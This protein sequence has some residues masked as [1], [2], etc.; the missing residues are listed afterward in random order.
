MFLL[1]ILKQ[2]F[3]QN[4]ERND[5]ADSTMVG[6]LI[7]AFCF[8]SRKVFVV[9]YF[10]GCCDGEAGGRCVQSLYE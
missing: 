5:P 4:R 3:T 9:Y 6:W 8:A 1:K 7:I 10:L 2:N